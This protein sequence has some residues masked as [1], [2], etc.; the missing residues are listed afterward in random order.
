[1]GND[2]PKTKA[3]RIQHVVLHC[4]GVFGPTSEVL[5][6]L[7]AS[8]YISSKHY[9]CFFDADPRFIRVECDAGSVHLVPLTNVASI[10]LAKEAA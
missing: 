2:Q 8:G 10:T 7:Y 4:A 5:Q 1:M 6:A 3:P 9:K